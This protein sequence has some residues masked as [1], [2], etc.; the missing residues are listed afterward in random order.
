MFQPK[1][2]YCQVYEIAPTLGLDVPRGKA[3]IN[4]IMHPSFLPKEIDIQAYL[5]DNWKDDFHT[6]EEP[7]YF[8]Q[9][10]EGDEESDGLEL[11][12]PQWA[13]EE[14]ITQGKTEKAQKEKEKI[15]IWEAKVE[16]SPNIGWLYRNKDCLILDCECVDEETEQY[17]YKIE[18]EYY[19]HKYRTWISAEYI[20]I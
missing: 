7:W 2:E 14:I 6:L 17:K 15:Q 12:L 10:T 1:F 8:F 19:G 3:V 16:N 11:N 5:T 18:V 9:I 4:G 13:L 20:Q